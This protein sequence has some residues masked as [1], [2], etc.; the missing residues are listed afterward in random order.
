VYGLSQE[1]F[2][3]SVL[4][5][6]EDESFHL[7]CREVLSK[8]SRKIEILGPYLEDEAAKIHLDFWEA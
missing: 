5:N 7:A 6:K 3:A 1:R 8:G 4:G 2:H